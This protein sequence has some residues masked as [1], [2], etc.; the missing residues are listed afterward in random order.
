MS[1]YLHDIPLDDARNRFLE[2]FEKYGLRGSNKSELLPLNEN[3]VGRVLYKPIWA[4]IS[5]PHYHAS[6]MDGF[7]L[8]SEDIRNAMPTNPVMVRVNEQATYVDTGDPL[9]DWAN[10]VI[11]I[12]NTEALDEKG[13]ID[14]EKRNPYWIRIRSSLAPWT[15]IRPMGEDIVATELVLPANRTLIPVDLG[16]IAACGFTEVE[17]VK[18]P[19]VTILPTGTELVMIGEDIKSGDIIEYN[20]IVLGAQVKQWGGDV[21]RFPITKDDFDELCN[22]VSNAANQSDLIL[23]NAGSSAG[24]EDY[25]AKVIENLGE[26][27]VHGVAVRP[28]HPVI[29]GMVFS[30]ENKPVPVIGVPGYPVSA[31]LTGE[32]FVRPIIE[33]WAGTPETTKEIIEAEL[34]KKITSPAGD[35]DYLR[36]VVAKVG[37]KLL[38]AP[39]SRGAGVITSMVRSDGYAVIPRGIQGKEAGDK[40]YVHLNKDKNVLEHTLLTLGSHDLT[41]DLL[42]E[43]LSLKGKRLV[44]AN[45]GSLGGLIS[46]NRGE[47]HFSGSHLF[48]PIN[49]N[50]NISYVKK[51]I[52]S[53]KTVII[54][55]VFREQG[56]IVQKGNPKD[57]RNL[58]DLLRNDVNYVNRQRGA[59]TRILL[60]YH[61]DKLKINSE[62]I[63][64]YEQEEYTHLNVAAAVKSNRADTGLGITAAAK[65]LELDFIPLFNERY[66]LIVPQHFYTSDIFSSVL[67]AIEDD[68]FRSR[69]Q[70]LAGY[71]VSCMGKDLIELG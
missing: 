28:G 47:A 14:L 36:V 70:A 17:V 1:I 71:D 32:I 6:A 26:V 10:C 24:S 45:V 65:A 66:D 8:R 42:A 50:F 18:K 59:G 64:G 12:E 27:Y 63:H 48:D 3:L 22:Q 37:E 69:V 54:P 13:E 41:L 34:T 39:L 67:G 16:A 58:D 43:Y 52:K 31:A 19:V 62:F 23:I 11:P 53:F 55:W 38:A 29:L 61:L 68:E 49:E 51:Y 57:I 35:D 30:K 15:H 44:S 9:P 4:K 40:V 56:L 2:A 46:L 20:S 5:S 60:D 25:T 33:E 7:A 21:V